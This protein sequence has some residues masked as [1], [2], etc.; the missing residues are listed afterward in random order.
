MAEM[1]ANNTCSDGSVR[2]D[3]NTTFKNTVTL[4]SKDLLFFNFLVDTLDAG[5]ICEA[6]NDSVTVSVY[7]CHWYLDYVTLTHARRRCA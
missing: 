5:N 1:G 2:S 4:F 7:D 3:I 6:V